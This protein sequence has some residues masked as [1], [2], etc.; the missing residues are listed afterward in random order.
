MPV[1]TRH[2]FHQRKVLGALVRTAAAAAR[3]RPTEP[4]PTPGPE[5]TE[6]IPARS[7]KL[8]S[9]YI[10]HCGGSTSSYKKVV[11]AH[12]FPQW[13]FPL[14]SRTLHD[15]SYDLRRV[16]NGGCRIE[17]HEPLLAGE[18]LHL[19]ARLEDIDDNDRRAV[20][21]QHLV[22][23]TQHNPNAMEAWIYAIVPKKRTGK[24][25]PKKARPQVPLDAQEIARWRLGPKAGLE[26][27]I[28][29]GDFNPV[30]WVP[31]YARMAGFKNTILHGFSTLARA[32]E[33][34]NANVWSGDTRKLHTIDVKFVRP[35]ILPSEVG[36]FIRGDGELAVG[37]APGGP[38]YLTGTFTT[39]D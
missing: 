27:A 21:K 33:S 36:V 16:L 35:V 28:L 32:I 38:A 11:P 15:V 5:I 18:R 20:I 6:D 2:V 7:A 3:T 30:H 26:F 19:R 37:S 25:G 22:T 34:L 29:T 1:A 13:G 24:K 23:G 9:D 39:R 4:V 12:L 31:Q 17:I 10:R 8:V 14:M